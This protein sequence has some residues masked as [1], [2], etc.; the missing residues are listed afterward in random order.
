MKE[1]TTETEEDRKLLD[2]ADDCLNNGLYKEAS[3]CFKTLKDKS[4]LLGINQVFSNVVDSVISGD[5]NL[6]NGDYSKAINDYKK[7][8]RSKYTISHSLVGLRIA[9]ILKKGDR[10]LLFG[11]IDEALE[12]YNQLTDDKI[13]EGMDESKLEIMANLIC[14]LRIKTIHDYYEIL[15]H[16]LKPKLSSK[17]KGNVYLKI[18]MYDKAKDCY[19]KSFDE[20]QGIGQTIA[21]LIAI[22]IKNNDLNDLYNFLDFYKD[23]L[24]HVEY[25][26]IRIYINWKTNESFA[27]KYEEGIINYLID[28]NK[29]D[30]CSDI[31]IKDLFY[32]IK[33]QVADGSLTNGGKQLS[34]AYYIDCQEP[35][36]Y[37]RNGL[38]TNIV[39]VFSFMEKDNIIH[40]YPTCYDGPTI[41]LEQKVKRF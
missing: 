35:V 25:T 31:D 13:Y 41:P 1:I 22:K 9:R 10:E 40:M 15:K 34:S 21:G 16:G 23:Q 11:N 38:E 17:D 3:A 39:K 19:Y 29:N 7:G 37:D 36:G 12:I 27:K 30:Y 14:Y 33:E 24:T 28:N 32:K 20:D 26:R 8:L 2:L 5:E 4:K 18:G 6:I